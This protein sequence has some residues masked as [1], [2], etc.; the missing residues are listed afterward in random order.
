LTFLNASRWPQ[1]IIEF[2]KRIFCAL[3][4]VACLPFAAY[5]KSGSLPVT[6]VYSSQQAALDQLLRQSGPREVPFVTLPRLVWLPDIND[7][8]TMKIMSPSDL[9]ASF[10]PGVELNRVVL[11][12]TNSA[13]TPKPQI[14]P[15]WPKDEL[16]NGGFEGK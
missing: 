7:K 6:S 2:N 16:Q 9:S 12:L 8:K 3:N 14:W 4:D 15:Q 1:Q 11:E 5:A 10:G 13:I